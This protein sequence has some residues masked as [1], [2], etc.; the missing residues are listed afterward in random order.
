MGTALAA[1]S[2]IGL[3]GFVVHARGTSLP[4]TSFSFH[5][6]DCRLLATFGVI[7]FGLVGLELGSVMGDEIRDPRR[8]VPQA[9]ILGGIICAL[10][11]VGATLAVLLA[12]PREQIGVVQGI[13]QA[14]SRMA[15]QNGLGWFVPPLAL[16]LTLSTAGIASA[17]FAGSA[18]VPFVAGLDRYLPAGL[19][20][21]H[22]RYR[23]PYI[24][25]LVHAG[26][27]SFFLA[28]SFVGATVGEAYLTMLDLAVVLQLIPFLYMYGGL[29]HLAA[30]PSDRAGT[31]G[32]RTLW[33]SGTCGLVATAFGTGL[34]FVPSHKIGS[35][36]LFELKMWTGV[37]L[38]VGVASVFFRISAA[39]RARKNW[40]S[41][42]V[43]SGPVGGSS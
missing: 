9:V 40:G 14:V 30:R 21:V 8:T 32:R 26:L 43:H 10:L 27:S 4:G 37:G 7:C 39:R 41:V 29:L 6:L 23:T 38:F 12:V 35:V 33:V 13:L 15:G 2:L 36:G 18:R 5:G 24:A 1:V 31:Y 19:G 25:L 11:Y 16:V 17:W 28:M 22:P 34:A 20:K 42:S 3:A